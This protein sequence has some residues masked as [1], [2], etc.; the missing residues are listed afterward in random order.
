MLSKKHITFSGQEGSC[1]KEIQY[2]TAMFMNTKALKDSITVFLYLSVIENPKMDLH[3]HKNV[4][5][6]YFKFMYK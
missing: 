1:R 3:L 2:H 4:V 5:H 6:Y